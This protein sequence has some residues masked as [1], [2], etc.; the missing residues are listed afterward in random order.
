MKFNV[1]KHRIQL[2]IY[3]LL[4]IYLYLFSRDY[5]AIQVKKILPPKKGHIIN[6]EAVTETP[7]I[8]FIM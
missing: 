3:I 2:T 4:R 6:L 1:S 5:I 7:K 8:P